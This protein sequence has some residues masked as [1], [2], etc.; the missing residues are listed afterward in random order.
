MFLFLESLFNDGSISVAR[1]PHPQ[2]G[3]KCLHRAQI[4][5]SRLVNLQFILNI[6]KS[7]DENL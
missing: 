3:K 6:F 5:L 7:K 4:N 1:L 2:N